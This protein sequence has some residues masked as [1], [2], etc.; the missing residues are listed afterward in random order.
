MSYIAR[1]TRSSMLDVIHQEYIRTARAKGVS[2]TKIIF[3]HAL[4]NSVIPVITSLGPLTAG[5]ITGSFVIESVFN[6]PGLGR[7]YIQSI[8][9]R[10]YPIIMATTVFYAALLISMN[11]LVDIIYKFID[12]R[13]DI[14]GEVE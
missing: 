6:I 3:K 7:Y 5:I 10:D 2:P 4:R 9:G 8:I 14:T 11:L 1:L 12:P 13:I